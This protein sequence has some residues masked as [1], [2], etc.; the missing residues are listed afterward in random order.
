MFKAS[1]QDPAKDS[2]IL[3]VTSPVKVGQAKNGKLNT[4]S[5]ALNDLLETYA[6]N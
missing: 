6:S 4:S 1:L 2:L 3:R 5:D